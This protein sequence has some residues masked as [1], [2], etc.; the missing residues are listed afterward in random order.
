[1]SQARF[2]AL[3]TFRGGR[4]RE[5]G[6]WAEVVAAVWLMA[7]GWRI[8]GFRLKSPLGEID[9]LARRGGILAAVEVKRRT[10]LEAALSAVSPAQAA[11]L[12]RSAALI[13]ANRP[14]LERLSIRLDI[15]ALAPG[16][17]PRHIPGAWGPSG[18]LNLEARRGR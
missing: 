11:R 2:K 14:D 7:K 15:V 3:R 9:I 16:R 12:R 18:D 8:L 6:R 10:T 1:V 13:A 17:R 5:E 4:A